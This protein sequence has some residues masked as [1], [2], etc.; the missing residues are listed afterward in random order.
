MKLHQSTVLNNIELFLNTTGP[1]PALMRYPNDMFLIWKTC[2]YF[3]PKNILEIG[4]YKGQT[5]GLIYEASGTDSQ[6]TSVDI[7]YQRKDLFD[8]LFPNPAGKFLNISSKDL[9]LDEKF[10]FVH[11]DGNHSYEYVLNDVHKVLPWLHNNSIICMD[12]FNLPGVDQV[13]KEHLMGQHDFVPFMSGDQEM[14]FRHVSYATDEFLDHWIQ[15][16]AN[17][18]IYFHNWDYHGYTLLESKT[19]N[20]FVENRSMFLQALQFYNL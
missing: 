14:F 13:I 2:E 5:L 17:N 18:F 10:D 4:F 1:D 20:L 15:D 9:T 12:D 16:K 6:F 8:Q 3:Q 11:I 7:R 19:P